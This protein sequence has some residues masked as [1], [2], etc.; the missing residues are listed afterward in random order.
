LREGLLAGVSVLVAGAGEERAHGALAP[1]VLDAC[2]ALGA[3]IASCEILTEEDHQPVDEDE[4][5]QVF[6]DALGEDCVLDLMAV[7]A[8][9]VFAAAQASGPDEQAALRVC[10]QASWAA[11][12]AAANVAFLKREPPA[13]RIV[14]LAP[15]ARAG[16][17]ARAVGAGLENL[18]RTL[19]IEW[20]RHQITTVAILAGARQAMEGAASLAREAAAL[21]AYLA[22]PAGAYFSGCALELGG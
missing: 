9:G 22:S 5:A 14:Y 3:R 12:H 2:G 11:T 21:T 8:A 13:G 7:D 4:L 18:A 17:Q 16:A 15:H 20:A 1:A 10:M 19:S 6:V